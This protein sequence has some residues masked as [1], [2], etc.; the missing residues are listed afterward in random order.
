[1]KEVAISRKLKQGEKMG[2]KSMRYRIANMKSSK[3]TSPLLFLTTLQ[4]LPFKKIFLRHLIMEQHFQF[5]AIVEYFLPEENLFE[6]KAQLMPTVTLILSH[7]KKMMLK[8]YLVCMQKHNINYSEN[9][10]YNLATLSGG[11]P[12]GIVEMIKKYRGI[13]FDE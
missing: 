1:M 7:L 8:I 13:A 4:K 5:I 6:I 10:I 3:D 2:Y 11:Y 9:Y 12:L